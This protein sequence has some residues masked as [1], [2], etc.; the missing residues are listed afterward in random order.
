MNHVFNTSAVRL[1][2]TVILTSYAW[3]QGTLFA[4]EEAVAQNKPHNQGMVNL[5]ESLSEHEAIMANWYIN[6]DHQFGLLLPVTWR[7]SLPRLSL[8]GWTRIIRIE[9]TTKDTV[10]DIGSMDEVAD[11]QDVIAGMRSV[12]ME[13]GGDVSD[14]EQLR[15]DHGTRYTFHSTRGEGDDL[16]L[17]QHWVTHA[18]GR[19]AI[20]RVE[21]GTPF[22]LDRAFYILATHTLIE[23]TRAT[24][25]NM[26]RHEKN[27]PANHVYPKRRVEYYTLNGKIH[28][29]AKEI[30]IDDNKLIL[31]YT[32]HNGSYHGEDLIFWPNGNLY[33]K[34]W[35]AFGGLSG[36]CAKY[37]STG[38][39]YS[40]SEWVDDLMH[41]VMMTYY[42]DGSRNTRTEAENGK[43]VGQRKHYLPSGELI[44]ITT[45]RDGEITNVQAMREA[46]PTEYHIMMSAQIDPDD[47]W[48]SR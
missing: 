11:P 26:S 41:G 19:L 13:S 3:P 28:G 4:S 21:S 2:I 12:I 45:F 46:S 1:L 8:D 38:E 24:I 23:D 5:T 22:E 47:V 17:E 44:G 25:G 7:V 31:A 43:F 35:N 16:R 34:A 20:W 14:I 39:L 40:I 29:L 30:K 37:Y 27:V 6:H 15:I 18:F 42:R 10:I 36:P 9:S 32:A 33:Q 48:R